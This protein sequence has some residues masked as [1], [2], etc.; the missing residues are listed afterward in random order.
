LESGIGRGGVVDHRGP[1]H[2]ALGGPPRLPG[3][4][5]C[6]RGTRAR[7]RGAPSAL[8]RRA[9]ELAEGGLVIAPDLFDRVTHAI[10]LALPALANRL[11]D[12]P[13]SVRFHLQFGVTRDVEQAQARRHPRACPRQE[14]VGAE[15]A[16]MGVRAPWPRKGLGVLASNTREGRRRC[17]RH[18]RAQLLSQSRGCAQ[19]SSLRAFP[20][21]EV[22]LGHVAK[23]NVRL[24]RLGVSL[25]RQAEGAGAHHLSPDGRGSLAEHAPSRAQT[26]APHRSGAATPESREACA[27]QVRFPRFFFLTFTEAVDGASLRHSWTANREA[28]PRCVRERW[29]IGVDCS[30]PLRLLWLM[31]LG[32]AEQLCAEHPQVPEA[33]ELL[34]DLRREER[35]W[36]GSSLRKDFKRPSAPFLS[37]PRRTTNVCAATPTYRFHEV[38]A[39]SRRLTPRCRRQDCL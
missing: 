15:C 26:P 11:D 33:G 24:G 14:G 37:G 7:L 2:K 34:E 16:V 20:A 27:A 22:G 6:R 36:T 9:G 31:K 3:N 8:G 25:R 17:E 13:L 10:L 29:Q 1:A 38:I 35:V 39:G 12:E 5:T 23:K 21:P 32:Q 30:A 18:R 19:R 4:T 28:S